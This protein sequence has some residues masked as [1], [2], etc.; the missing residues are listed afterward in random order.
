LTQSRINP[1]TVPIE[2]E[3]AASASAIEKEDAV[4]LLPEPQPK[5]IEPVKK[6]V[7]QKQLVTKIVQKKVVRKQWV[8][9]KKEKPKSY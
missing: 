3:T 1:V 6:F 5:Q 2:T 8:K 7:K 4:E 9:R